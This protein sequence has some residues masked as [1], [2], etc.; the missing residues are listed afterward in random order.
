MLK[1][2]FAQGVKPGVLNM[3]GIGSDQMPELFSIKYLS[4]WSTRKNLCARI[5]QMTYLFSLCWAKL[6]QEKSFHVHCA[7]WISNACK[8]WNFLC[9][10][11]KDKNGSSA[12]KMFWK[13]ELRENYLPIHNRGN[14]R[15]PSKWSI[16]LFTLQQGITNKCFLYFLV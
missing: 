7:R 13:D 15:Q 8:K 6:L 12:H 11:N 9:S 2:D 14:S 16:T 1:N 4:P 10:I 5:K 3:K